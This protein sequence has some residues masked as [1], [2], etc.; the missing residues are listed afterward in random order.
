MRAVFLRP[1]VSSSCLVVMFLPFPV[2][3]FLGVVWGLSGGPITAT[4]LKLELTSGVSVLAGSVISSVCQLFT[5][6]VGVMSG[7]LPVHLVLR[8]VAVFIRM[9]LPVVLE[10]D[11]H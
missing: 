4:G 2:K 1:Q 11:G 6:S 10:G 3:P 9:D 7:V 5:G 8:A